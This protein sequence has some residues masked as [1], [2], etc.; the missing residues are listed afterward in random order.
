MYKLVVAVR[1]AKGDRRI[2]RLIKTHFH[3]DNNRWFY[4]QARGTAIDQ[5]QLACNLTV[6]NAKKHKFE[7]RIQVI[8]HKLSEESVL[9]DIDD[10]FD[11]IV[12]NP[13]YVPNGD[14]PELDPEIKL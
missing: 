2:I 14:L 1:A 7:N 11:L 3:T 13:P 10:G 12:S 8:R 6:E 9:D 5:S 4:L